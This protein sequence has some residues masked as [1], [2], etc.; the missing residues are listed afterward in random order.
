MLAARDQENLVHGHQQ[1]AAGKPLNQ[2]NRQ[3]APKTP[4]NRYPKTPLKVP[5]NDENGIG[6]QGG[7]FGLKTNGKGN[8]NMINGGKKMGL[9]DKNALVTPM[10]K[11]VQALVYRINIKVIF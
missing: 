6:G 10:G 2:G 4:G 11:I 9:T 3:L 5:L 7:K 8:E 1:A